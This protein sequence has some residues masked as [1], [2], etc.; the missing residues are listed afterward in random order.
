[1]FAVR[2]RVVNEP[3]T[4]IQPKDIRPNP[5]NHLKL[6]PDPKVK[7]AFNNLYDYLLVLL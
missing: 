2:D 4:V 7:F 5:K 6:K 1:M 3:T